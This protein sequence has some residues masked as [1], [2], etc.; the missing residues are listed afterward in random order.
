MV[1]RC[2]VETVETN[3][4]CDSKLM[5]FMRL[6]VLSCVSFKFHWFLALNEIWVGSSVRTVKSN[7]SLSSTYRY[8]KKNCKVGCRHLPHAADSAVTTSKVMSK[9]VFPRLYC[10][11][12]HRKCYYN[13][14]L[15]SAA[16]HGIHHA[17]T[18][19]QYMVPIHQHSVIVR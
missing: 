15:L 14:Q 9:W 4:H 18:K 13:P 5:P 10:R 19:L 1:E 11:C 12:G 6:F 3:F 17:V 2:T 7:V 16:H 8:S